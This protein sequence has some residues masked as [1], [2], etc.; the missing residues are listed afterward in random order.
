ML[1]PR[2]RELSWV[3]PSLTADTQRE[4]A[5][6]ADAIFTGTP[7]TSLA[8]WLDDDSRTVLVRGKVPDGLADAD[9]PT[10]VVPGPLFR[11]AAAKASGAPEYFPALQILPGRVEFAYFP[12]L[13]QALLIV[14]LP[15]RAGACVIGADRARCFE[16][17]DVEW[18]RAVAA[19]V[20]RVVGA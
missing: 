8:L 19:R 10:L 2:S 6:A 3:D 7:A 1:Q 9:I 18:V 17:E 4:L 12:E 14:P 11:K 15:G 16:K 5:W 13:T 20:G